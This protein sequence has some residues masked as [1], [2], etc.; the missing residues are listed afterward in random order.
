MVE[1]NSQ[2]YFIFILSKFLKKLKFREIMDFQTCYLQLKIILHVHQKILKESK[3]MHFKRLFI[4]Y[5]VSFVLQQ[6]LVL[7]INGKLTIEKTILFSTVITHLKCTILNKLYKIY[8][9]H[10]FISLLF[11][12]DY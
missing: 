6:K 10:S 11:H 5:Q 8:F 3:G 1:Q 12:A 7:Q 2:H 9:L 4:T